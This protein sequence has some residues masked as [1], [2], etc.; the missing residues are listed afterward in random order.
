MAD[1]AAS[2]TVRVLLHRSLFCSVFAVAMVVCAYVLSRMHSSSPPP[3][4]HGYWLWSL[5]RAPLSGHYFGHYVMF[6]VPAIIVVLTFLAVLARR[7]ASAV[8]SLSVLAALAGVILTIVHV[9]HR[10]DDMSIAPLGFLPDALV[11]LACAI[12]YL[13]LKTFEASGA[14][15]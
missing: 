8:R 11:T 6:W 13:S 3:T 10:G 2:R 4:V 15:P 5:W 1:V 9:A 7:R 14:A 12:S